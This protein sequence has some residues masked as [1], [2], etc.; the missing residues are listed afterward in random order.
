MG[1]AQGARQQLQRLGWHLQE[2]LGQQ[3]SHSFSFRC[4]SADGQQEVVARVLDTGGTEG[5][6][7]RGYTD[8]RPSLN[9]YCLRMWL[10]NDAPTPRGLV[11]WREVRMEHKLVLV[12]DYFP[13]CMRDLAPDASA[14]TVP[15][16]SVQLLVKLQVLAS[17]VDH[18]LARAELQGL[19]PRV[20]LS[21]VFLSGEQ[22]LLAD[23]GLAEPMRLLLEADPGPHPMS[24]LNR[25]SFATSSVLG[26]NPGFAG[27][28][29]DL[30]TCYH[31]LRTGR[32]PYV[33]QTDSMR[34]M[35]FAVARGE[36]DL[37]QLPAKAERNILARALD[38]NPARRQGS[39]TEL[40]AELA[41]IR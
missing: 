29:Q 19:Q 6:Y 39:A 13:H 35:L 14:S 21:N 9:G 17:T 12:R 32:L 4:R 33:V 27:A 3:Y 26:E 8:Q 15:R 34:E 37:H 38:P 18:C 28:V 16:P 25:F 22:V 20:V 23:W 41:A 31:L 11:P 36:L 7:G 2:P 30:A 1:S 10:H 5:N 40:M 24:H